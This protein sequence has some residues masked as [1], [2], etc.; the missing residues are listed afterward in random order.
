MEPKR[1]RGRDKRGDTPVDF[2][3]DTEF[4]SARVLVKSYSAA[5]SREYDKEESVD[6]RHVQRVKGNNIMI[7]V[8]DRTT[9]QA[10]YGKNQE[11]EYK[12]DKRASAVLKEWDTINLKLDGGFCTFSKTRIAL[13]QSTNGDFHSSMKS[14]LDTVYEVSCQEY[15]RLLY[16][17][18]VEGNYNPYYNANEHGDALNRGLG[19]EIRAVIQIAG[20]LMVKHAV[21]LQEGIK[22]VLASVK[23]SERERG[24]A[25]SCS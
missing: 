4:N 6:K 3:K 21:P 18:Q 14:Q 15:E 20:G 12:G 11:T 13:M 7:Q 2:H 24:H 1:G 17:A 16:R 25:P 19:Y 8:P 22:K 10:F 5:A 23:R 9:E